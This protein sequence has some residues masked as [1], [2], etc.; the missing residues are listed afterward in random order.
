MPDWTEAKLQELVRNQVQEG[1]TLDYKRSAALEK[2][3]VSRNELAK[4]VSAFA[5]AAGGTLIYG[6]VENGHL[7]EDLDDGLSPVAITREWIEQILRSR[8]Q[9]TIPDITITS[10]PLSGARAGRVAYV[11]DIARGVTAHQAPDRKYYKRLNFANEPMLDYEVRDVM[12]RGERPLVEPVFV[13]R[14]KTREP[15]LHTYRLM[16]E[17]HNLGG[18]IVEYLQLRFTFPQI[19]EAP[20]SGYK[21]RALNMF[22]TGLEYPAH[23][24][25]FTSVDRPL[26]PLERVNLVEWGVEPLTYRIDART[27]EWL[28]RQKCELRWVM[29]ADSMRRREGAIPVSA[30]HEF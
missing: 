16:I 12:H 29:Y 13:F 17:L 24:F 15:H 19:A 18:L 28:S 26:F 5:N 22:E 25:I 3:E 8:I 23:E 20:F 27:A 11:I 4:D 21:V 2:T 10:V 14:G 1:P 6:I 30:L 7:P 9:P